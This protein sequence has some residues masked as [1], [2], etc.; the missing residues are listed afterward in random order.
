M[1]HCLL[2]G[3]SSQIGYF[4]LPELLAADASVQVLAL[5]RRARPDYLAKHERLCWHIAS[6]VDADFLQ[7]ASISEIISLGPLQLTLDAMPQ[8]VGLQRV[9]AVTSSSILVK[10]D[11][12]DAFEREQ[13]HALAAAERSLIERCQQRGIVCQILR[14]T[15][16]Y[17]AGLDANV[18][19]LAKLAASPGVIPV[20]GRATGLRRPVHAADIAAAVLGLRQLA[21]SGHWIVTGGSTLSYREL[22]EN[23]CQ[24]MQRGRVIGVPA[25]VLNTM[26]SA[27]HLAGRLRSVN[28]GMIVRQNQDLLFD[29]R[30]AITDFGWS[31][32]AF[33]LSAAMLRAPQQPWQPDS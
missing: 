15:M 7:A 12:V 10:Q 28:A 25:V 9:V 31:P 21:Q 1:S 19:A 14:P 5:A 11:S 30:A 33:Q 32:R 8:C 6:G 2:T 29:D 26:L 22:A 23:V 16:I 4:L 13:I 18:C 27:A 3:G 24:A 20:A 17:G